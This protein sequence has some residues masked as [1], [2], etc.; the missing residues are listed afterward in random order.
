MRDSI[1]GIASATLVIKILGRI[2]KYAI[3][4]GIAFISGADGL[5]EIAFYMILL[6]MT[7]SVA[8]FG[9]DIAAQRFIQEGENS[10]RVSSVHTLALLIPVVL[11]TLIGFS[12]YQFLNYIYTQGI[13]IPIQAV[14]IVLLTPAVGLIYTTSGVAK[15]HRK[16]ERGI[17]IRELLYSLGGATFL[18]TALL[19]TESVGVAVFAYSLGIIGAS[20]GAI[21]LFPTIM[22]V[23]VPTVNTVR[24]IIRYCTFAVT[25]RLSNRITVWIDVLMLGFFVSSSE[26]GQY[27]L[28]YQ[29]AALLG[30]ALVS[31]NSVFPTIAAD[32]HTTNQKY[33]LKITYIVI[34]KWVSMITML[35][36]GWLLLSA[37]SFLNIFGSSFA[38]QTRQVLTIVIIAQV[39]VASAGPCGEL[40]LMSGEE[41]LQAVNTII[42]AFI[43]LV[44]NYMLIPQLGIIGAAIATSI[45]IV[46]LNIFRLFE[47]YQIHSIFPYKK[48]FFRLFPHLGVSY[49]VLFLGNYVFQESFLMDLVI[50]IGALITFLTLST[51]NLNEEDRILISAI[52]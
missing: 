27:Q 34:T 14:E 41:K 7:G 40:L 37:D 50:G 23:S 46:T 11:G 2:S 6:N 48:E 8:A 31:V 52:R 21:F 42:T 30:F 17:Q 18:I 28:A 19:I 26:L 51:L 13:S 35:G 43:N 1:V 9:L 36:A 45:S 3:T 5:G 39:L 16:F 47:M 12:T 44:L 32:Y 25:E 10:I 20:I 22:D 33:K 38:G 15:G 49:L 4:A 24:R 29:T